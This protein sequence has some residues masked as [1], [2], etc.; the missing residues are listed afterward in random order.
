MA[1]LEL[2]VGEGRIQRHLCLNRGQSLGV[3]MELRSPTLANRGEEEA[4]CQICRFL[5][6]EGVCSHPQE[7]NRRSYGIIWERKGEERIRKGKQGSVVV[8]GRCP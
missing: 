5:V 7:L 3:E 2:E 8:A 6:V 1:K 4:A